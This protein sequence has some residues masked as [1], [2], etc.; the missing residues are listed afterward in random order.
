V[1]TLSRQACGH[2]PEHRLAT[3]ARLTVTSQSTPARTNGSAAGVG[4]QTV[5]PRQNHST[6]YP[7]PP[8]TLHKLSVQFQASAEAT[9]HNWNMLQEKENNLPRLLLEQ[10]FSVMTPGSEFRLVE[11]LAGLLASHPLWGRWEEGL[12]HGVTY[13][14]EPYSDHDMKLDLAAQ[15]ERGNHQSAKASL[16]VLD[17]LNA[18]DV[19]R[20]YSFCL[21]VE[22]LQ[23]ID[24]LAAAPHGVVHQ[25][26][27]NELGQLITKDCPA[28]D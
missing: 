21:P 18:E 19:E 13:P 16:G 22:A 5:P 9:L 24:E 26:T 3:P 14:L 6:A 20:G 17:K 4:K 27:I 25:G 7:M 15:L 8:C 10:L 11:H 28:H 23:A 12:N 2:Q 1:A